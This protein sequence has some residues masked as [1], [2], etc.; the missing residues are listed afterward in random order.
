VEG[1]SVN[2]MASLSEEATRLGSIPAGVM[3]AFTLAGLGRE[4]PKNV[5]GALQHLAA[6]IILCSIGTEL[7]PVLKEATG[8]QQCVS[9]AVGF[10]TGVALLL[11]LGVLLPEHDDDNNSDGAH[12][13]SSSSSSGLLHSSVLRAAIQSK[14]R[15]GGARRSSDPEQQPLTSGA[16]PGSGSVVFPTSLVVA[17]TID[18]FIDGLLIGLVTGAGGTAGPMLSA[19]LS[20]EMG[21]LGLTLA[22][23]LQGQPSF[24]L[25]SLPAS[26][27]GPLGCT[28]GYAVPRSFS[29]SAFERIPVLTCLHAS[30][31]PF[32]R[33]LYG[34]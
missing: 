28:L 21:F 18:A 14:E 3:L 24:W 15:A 33:C 13:R 30:L 26:L 31:F 8:W 1:A 2:I 12:R 29:S 17:L 34:Q 22:T 16:A 10:F 7:L 19:S 11:V 32:V 9:S 27:L 5:A 6:G 25:R 23:A 4:V 20:V